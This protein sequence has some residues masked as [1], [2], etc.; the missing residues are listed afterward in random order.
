MCER[1]RGVE[2]RAA[3]SV[4]RCMV[5]TDANRLGHFRASVDSILEMMSGS[6]VPG[7]AYF[8]WHSA[9]YSLRPEEGIPHVI[10]LT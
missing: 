4:S 2:L 10:E 8:S 7:A 9:R 3:R 6:G 5:C 1:R